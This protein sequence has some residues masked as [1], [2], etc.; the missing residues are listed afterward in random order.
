MWNVRRAAADAAGARAWVFEAERGGDHLIEF[1]EWQG[2]EGTSIVEQVDLSLALDDLNAAF[3][4][5]D[6][7]TWL[8][9]KI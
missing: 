4:T 9:A 8:E 2:V 1:V 7:D 3:P 6:S 5:E